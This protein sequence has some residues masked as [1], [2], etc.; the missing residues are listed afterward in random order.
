M[1]TVAPIPFCPKY[2][3][4]IDGR[5]FRTDTKE[6]LSLRKIFS[7][8]K[9]VTLKLDGSSIPKLVHLLVLTA[10]KGGPPD[11][12]QIYTCDHMD[13]NRS[14]NCIDNLRW[15][16][17]S[18]Q[19]VNSARA[20]KGSTCP[21]KYKSI[22]ITK[23]DGE[24]IVYPCIAAAMAVIAPTRH[25]C[26]SSVYKA[27]KSGNKVFGCSWEY[28]PAPKGDFK[29]IPSPF[30]QG[31]QGYFASD[32]G[33][34]KFPS[35]RVF[36]GTLGTSREYATVNINKH[37]YRVH[38]LIAATFLDKADSQ[39]RVNHK[40]GNKTDNRLQNLEWTDAK[41]NT[42]HAYEIGL[43]QVADGKR[44]DQLDTAGRILK[45]FESLRAAARSVGNEP[46]YT[47]IIAC[48]KGR[49]KT[50]YGFKWAYHTDV[51]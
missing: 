51:A 36:S 20:Q 12:G 47:N 4:S 21:A 11:D 1:L 22:I 25:A 26:N 13:R 18:E 33:Y 2:S 40:N 10:F 48:C 50:A 15:A 9:T 35:G 7:G 44:L 30:I 3:A 46:G 32:T 17:Y 27:L 24:A 31:K 29:E 45:T 37:E 5:I 8:Y 14:N 42:E 23:E 38:R 16:T 6:Y 28:A 34:I 49:Q 41:G 19:F 39:D 43:Q